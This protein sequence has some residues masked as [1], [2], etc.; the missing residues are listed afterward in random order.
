MAEEH[1]LD[2][3]QVVAQRQVL[4][5]RRDAKRFGV[6]RTVEVDLPALPAI[7]PASGAQRPEIVLISDDLP[8]PLSPISAVTLPAGMSRSTPVSARTGPNVLVMPRSDSRTPPS[9]FAPDVASELSEML[10]AVLAPEANRARPS[11]WA[12]TVSCPS[13]DQLR[14]AV[15]VPRSQPTVQ[16]DA[17]LDLAVERPAHRSG[18]SGRSCP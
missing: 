15:R 13:R 3:V 4:V 1:V 6:L 7:S 12:G 16:A 14:R 9:P 11:S 2:D 18:S 17:H 5:D 8:A 10:I